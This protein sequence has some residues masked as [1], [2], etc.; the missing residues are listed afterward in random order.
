MY[1]EV[2][3]SRTYRYSS[4]VKL[5]L[6]RVIDKIKTQSFHVYSSQTQKVNGYSSRD[7]AAVILR[8]HGY[9]SQN[10]R[11]H[12]HSRV[13]ANKTINST[14]LGRHFSDIDSVIPDSALL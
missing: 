1:T 8:V 3:L 9:S 14:E 7:I 11:G 2:R 5:K 12:E 4:P 10:L 13:L 6:R